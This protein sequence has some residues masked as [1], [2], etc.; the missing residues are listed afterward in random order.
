MIRILLVITAALLL[1]S[2]SKTLLI[3]QGEQGYAGELNEK[4]ELVE[5]NTNWFKKFNT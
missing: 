3:T 4:Y 1:S 2:C 5:L